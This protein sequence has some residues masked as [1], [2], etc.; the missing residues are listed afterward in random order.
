MRLFP[1]NSFPSPDV[2]P[3][4]NRSIKKT[5]QPSHLL[6]RDCLPTSFFASQDARCRSCREQCVKSA[7]NL[8][9]LRSCAHFLSFFHQPAQR[10]SAHLLIGQLERPWKWQS[11][12][13]AVCLF[14]F[15]VCRLP[16]AVCT[17]QKDKN[18]G[19]S[20]RRMKHFP[21]LAHRV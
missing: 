20:G 1:P 6:L 10:A 14:P 3:T 15:A 2:L 16:F 19:L 21:T 12:Q 4:S 7:P 13:F 18:R 8:T 17:L 5:F 11:W 9:I